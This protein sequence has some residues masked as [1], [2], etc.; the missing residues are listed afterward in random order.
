[1]V[2]NFLLYVVTKSRTYHDP[3]HG[4]IVLAGSDP[5]ERLL[6]A[7]IDTPEF[8]RLRRIRQLDTA[9]FTF[10]GAEGSR[11]TH[12]LG[13][14]HLTRRAFWQ[15]VQPYPMLQPHRA[16]VLA[17]A[18]LHDVGHGPFSHAGE[19]VFGSHHEFWTLRLLRESS[20][21]PLLTAFDPS[22][23]EAIAAILSKTYPVPALSQ[24]VSSQLDCD[25]LDYLQRD[26]YYTGARYG[27]LDL[28]RILLALRFDPVSQQLVVSP[29]GTT[30]IEHYLMVRYFMYVQ[31]YN[32]PKNLAAR[33][34][35]DRIMARVRELVRGGASVFLDETARA[36][37][38]ENPATLS[39]QQYLA[40]DDTV[41]NYH[42]GRWQ[43]AA[44]PV[45]RDLCRR[46]QDRDLFK[47]VDITDREEAAVLNQLHQRLPAGCPPSYYVGIRHSLTKGYTLYAQGIALQTTAGL[48]EISDLSPVVQAIAQPRPKT[49]AIAPKAVLANLTT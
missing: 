37:L 17:A 20:L 28:D 19:E 11:F 18:L 6:M 3:L 33:F 10:H 47:A 12:A 44:D 1:M 43:T 49:W 24:L 40:A 2:T 34:T 38:L 21:H 7:L 39:W 35:L 22:L 42:L 9:F 25:R 31:V 32:H 5:V 26:S 13:V 8:Q 16:A 15:L 14:M 29:K 36:W 27:Q 48:Q 23:P 4:A 46:Y 30:A 45:L 41:F